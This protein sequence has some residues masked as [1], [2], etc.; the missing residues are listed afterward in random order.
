MDLNTLKQ[1]NNTGNGGAQYDIDD[2]DLNSGE[3]SYNELDQSVIGLGS[4][5]K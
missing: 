3:S 1:K 5:I 2:P 4:I